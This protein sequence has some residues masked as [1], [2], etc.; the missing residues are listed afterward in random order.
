MD[1]NNI[2]SDTTELGYEIQGVTNSANIK[3]S[4]GSWNDT[5]VTYASLCFSSNNL[6]G[7]VGVRKGEYMILNKSYSKEEYQ[8]LVE[9]II[10]QM[11]DM[12]FTDSTGRVYRYGE[13]FPMQLSPFAYNE[14]TSQEYFP[15]KKDE[16][17]KENFNWREGE[18]RK[19]N[20]T[21]KISDIN[22]NPSFYSDSIL[23]EVI[24]CEH[25]GTCADQCTTAFRIIESELKVYKEVG[26]PLPATCPNCRHI[27][28]LESR[29]IYN[30]KK[31]NCGCAG[32]SSQ[33]K[34][35][36]NTA[37]HVHGENTCPNTFETVFD[38]KNKNVYCKEC[39]QQ[40]VY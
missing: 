3:F 5:F 2:A 40:E 37:K 10:K 16:A 11:N 8:E 38:G 15:L 31:Q 1:A 26:I 13:F 29:R 7:C 28:R 9:K 39:Y 21:L 6:F 12:P 23:K 17:L 30:L 35:Y 19:Y 20:A 14:T 22:K 24:A 32:K 36:Q 4:D 33:N 27:E 18:E 34:S 25:N